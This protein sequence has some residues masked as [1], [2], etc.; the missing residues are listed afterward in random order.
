MN[1]Q[2][3]G[4]GP[5]ASRDQRMLR[6]ILR[7]LVR[8]VELWAFASESPESADLVP[9]LEQL[10]HLGGDRLSVKVTTEQGSGLAMAL[11]VSVR[12]TL[13]VVGSG[14]EFA[15]IE[16]WGAP[17]GYQFGALVGLLVAMSR[18]RNQLPYAVSRSLKN[19]THDVLLEV[20]VAPTCPHSPQVVRMA[21]DCALANPGR[22]AA[23]SVD[24]VQLTGSGAVASEA[25]PALTVY[26]DGRPRASHVGTL[27]AESMS[28]LIQ[29]SVKGASRHARNPHHR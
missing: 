6:E 22:I 5:L 14:G 19:L 2:T 17:R 18:G 23:R 15:P 16:I 20:G 12:P 25:V 10:D 3:V 28:R 27:S 1:G 21:Q 9:V 7:G 4:A 13:R 11:G 26:V 8:P 24:L 29:S